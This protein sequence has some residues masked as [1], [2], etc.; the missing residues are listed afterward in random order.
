MHW[1]DTLDAVQVDTPEPSVDVLANGWLLYQTLACRYV[2]RSGYYQSGGAFGFRDQLQDTMAT[3]HA[4][5]N[6]RA[7]TCCSA[8]RTSSRRATCCTGGIRRSDAACE[9]AVPTTICGCRWRPA[10]ICRRPATSACSTRR[11]DS[12]R[13]VLVNPDEESYYDL[14]VPSGRREFLRALRARRAT[15]HR[16][17]WRARP[18]ADRDRRLERR[19]EPRRRSRCGESVWLGFFLYDVLV[20]FGAVARRAATRPR[21]TSAP[22]GPRLRDNLATHAWDG[23]WFR[24]A[25]F[26]DGTPLGSASSDECRIDSISQS[27]SVLSGAVDP[28]RAQQAME[29]LD[30]YLVKR[31]AGL[32]LLLDPPF[33]KTDKDPGYIRGYVPGVRETAASTPTPRCGRRWRSRIWATASGRGSWRG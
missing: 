13:G 15:R 4:R 29:S 25:W 1:R 27:W 17:A 9:R 3:V 18:A 21:P 5:R 20:R 24:R 19:H 11:C 26:D 33:D 7:S 32:I 10:A 16:T 12:S 6:S 30:R 28:E 22:S 23:Q 2:A 8:P 14:P 31:E